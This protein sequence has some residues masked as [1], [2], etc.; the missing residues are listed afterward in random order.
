[1]SNPHQHA[2]RAK[3]RN[4]AYKPRPVRTPMLVGSEL[5]LRP[6]ERI[7]DRLEIDGTNDVDGRGT[8]VIQ[9]GNGEWYDA[10]G[11]LEG[12]QWHFEMMATRHGL[13]LPLDGL[14]ELVIA[15]R[16]CV[17]VKAST[18]AKLRDALPVLRRA[19]AT[20]DKDDQVDLLQQTRIKAEMEA[21]HG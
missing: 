14:R 6:L 10:A 9:D 16:Y 11:G 15:L 1:M 8:P 17:P 18:M 4:K 2:R 13:T 3:R 12:V 20:A 19:M 7:I 21:R 5:V